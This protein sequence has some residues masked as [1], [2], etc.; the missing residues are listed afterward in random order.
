MAL[1]TL[2]SDLG[3]RDF[4]L[5][6]LKGAIMSHAGEVAMVDVTHAIAPFNIKEAAFTISQSYRYFPEGTIHIVH[7]NSTDARNRL[8]LA[9]VNGHYI[10]TFD[11]GLL[12]IAFEKTP[13]QT[14]LVNEELM[15]N[16]SLIVEEAIAKVVNL[17]LTEYKPSD[18]AHLITESQNL[19]LLQPI[20]SSGQIRGTVIYIDHFG[21]AVVNITRTIL[22][23]FIALRPFT[24][25]VSGTG[26][27]NDLS[28]Q[29][30]DVE[31]GEL[32]CFFNATGYL[33][34]AINKGKAENLLGLKVDSP[35]LIMAR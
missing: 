30:A 14:Y 8:L 23:Q 6:A 7:V 28:T 5:A 25:Q 32:V 22:E 1:L 4:Y 16:N 2:T 18:F 33:E 27:T 13:H 35:I 34:V 3:T 17:L 26:S 31:E 15:E 10:I 20:T 11:N 24:I 12:S 29:Y 19:R 21:N 9:F